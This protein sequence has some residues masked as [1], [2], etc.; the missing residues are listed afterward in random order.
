MFPS[1]LPR[2]IGEE[3]P[4]YL[5]LTIEEQ[6]IIAQMLWMMTQTQYR[7]LRYPSG[8]ALPKKTIRRLWKTE[9]VMQRVIK[10]NYFSVFMGDNFSGYCS[11][12]FPEPYMC[13]ALIKVLEYEEPEVF[14]DIDGEVIKVPR[15]P[16]RSRSAKTDEGKQ[17]NS[18][19][20][21]IKCMHPIPV[22]LDSLDY[23]A[24]TTENSLHQMAALRILK[25]ARNKTCFGKIP[26]QYEQKKTG[27]I[28]EVL[29][30]LQSTPREVVRA[31][32]AGAWDYDI[33]N[34]HFAILSSWAK[35]LNQPS[36]IID[37]Y[38]SNKKETRQKLAHECKPD[39]ESKEAIKLIKKCLLSLVYGAVLNNDESRSTIGKTLGEES[40]TKFT[41]NEFVRN[42]TAEI[43][44]L[45]K[46][47]I[48]DLP[49]H[50]GR[51]GNHM[52]IYS[53]EK[54]PKKLLSH[55]LQGAEAI[56]LK[57][58]LE[59]FGTHILLCMHD[60][61]ISEKRLKIGDLERL[62]K[63]TTGFNLEVEETQIPIFKDHRMQSQSS[64][65]IDKS[66]KYQ[67][68]KNDC[69]INDGGNTSPPSSP[70]I[71]VSMRPSWNCPKGVKGLR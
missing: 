63:S 28:S 69:L 1:L 25:E 6:R 24:S 14:I 52:G 18:K 9:E 7:H 64:K 41:S 60:G 39:I 70:S 16:I 42:L 57:S 22:N 3:Y 67:L 10:S 49:R 59:H 19:W 23:F 53:D 29:N 37:F 13:R 65:G 4:P 30:G 36:P 38:L 45:Q 12:Y 8:I 15:N 68:I 44:T 54:D 27:R 61:W 40:A 20:K 50:A 31:A 34:C 47:I 51:Y 17:S 66:L 55:A 26:V 71:I 46:A 32:F 11:A 43:R 2:F 21:N 33:S 48:N 56:A 35:K 58:I 5:D 62:I